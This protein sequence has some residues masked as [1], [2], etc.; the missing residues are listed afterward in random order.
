MLKAVVWQ[1][2]ALAESKSHQ[3]WVWL[4]AGNVRQVLTMFVQGSAGQ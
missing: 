1:K 3:E 4:G 2:A